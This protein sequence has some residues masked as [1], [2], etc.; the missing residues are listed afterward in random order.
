MQMMDNAGTWAIQKET[1]MKEDVLDK[2]VRILVLGG[3]VLFGLRGVLPDIPGSGQ[4]PLLLVSVAAAVVVLAIG[5]YAYR[6]ARCAP[7]CNLKVCRAI[8]RWQ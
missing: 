8:Q 4:L 7:T 2:I 5:Q 3:L 6:C 1:D